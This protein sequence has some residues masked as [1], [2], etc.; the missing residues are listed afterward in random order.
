M[1]NMVEIHLLRGLMLDC[2]FFE[3]NDQANKSI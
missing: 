3:A 2:M 1:S